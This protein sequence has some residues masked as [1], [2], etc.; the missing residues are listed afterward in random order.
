MRGSSRFYQDFDKDSYIEPESKWAEHRPHRQGSDLMLPFRGITHTAG[1]GQRK[2]KMS[3]NKSEH[4]DMN[5]MYHSLSDLKKTPK[6]S[7]YKSSFSLTISKSRRSHMKSLTHSD[8][9]G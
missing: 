9:L 3:E 7:L 6:E 1:K 8:E 5:E 4:S 2:L